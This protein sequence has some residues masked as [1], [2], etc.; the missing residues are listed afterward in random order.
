M[1]TYKLATSQVRTSRIV[2]QQTHGDTVKRMAQSSMLTTM[3]HDEP[4]TVVLV[5]DPLAID[6]SAREVPESK[7]R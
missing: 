7:I 2:F 4:S 1:G 6:I 3:E 5:Q